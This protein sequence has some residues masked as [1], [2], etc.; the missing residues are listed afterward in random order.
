MSLGD[1]ALG[2]LRLFL[3]IGPFGRLENLIFETFESVALPSLVL[4]L[5]VK[6]AN[7]IHEA[8]KFT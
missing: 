5:G 7:A 2:I 3:L 6:N 4:S 1:V 8:F